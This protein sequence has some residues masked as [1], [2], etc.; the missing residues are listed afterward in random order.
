MWFN[1]FDRVGDAWQDDLRLMNCVRGRGDGTSCILH[2]SKIHG[3]F[4]DGVSLATGVE[5]QRKVDDGGRET[6]MKCG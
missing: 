6:A 4:G 2:G 1:N 5:T 3:V